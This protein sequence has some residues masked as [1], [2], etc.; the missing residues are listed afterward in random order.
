MRAIPAKP[1]MELR[2][3]TIIKLEPNFDLAVMF[4]TLFI[5]APVSVLSNT[6]SSV[7]R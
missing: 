3:S 6:V 1:K 7:R 5:S 2:P 4:S